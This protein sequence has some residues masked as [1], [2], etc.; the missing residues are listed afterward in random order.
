MWEFIVNLKDRKSRKEAK[1]KYLQHIQ[2]NS[3]YAFTIKDRSFKVKKYLKNT[4]GGASGG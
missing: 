3:K 1:A 4:S 2:I